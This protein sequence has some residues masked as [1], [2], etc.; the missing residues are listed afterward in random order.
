[1]KTYDCIVIGA[2]FYGLY[3]TKTLSEKGHKVLVLEFDDKPFERASFIN[4]ARVHN[5]YHY[6]RS[7]ETAQKSAHY[8]NRFTKD[9]DFAINKQFDQIYAISAKDS[10]TNAKQFEEFCKDINIPCE[11]IDENNY[12]KPGMVEAVFRGKEYAFDYKVIKDFLMEKI[13]ATKNVT[14]IYGSRI[15][16]ISNN[17][18]EI[19]IYD[20]KNNE[21]YKSD[22]VLN[23]TYA[24]LNQI[25]TLANLKTFQIK[26]ELCE[27]IF[28]K[29]SK[30]IDGVGLTIMDG[31]FF[32][33]MPFGLDGTY[34]L[35][36][37]HYTPHKT[38]FETLPNF[39]CME[40]NEFC[41]SN[42]LNNCNLCKF[43]PKSSFNEMLNLCN[44]YL[45]NPIGFETHQSAFAIKPIL[46]RAEGDDARPTLVEKLIEHPRFISVLSGKIDTVYDLDQ[47]LGEV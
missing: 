45:K 28:G 8:F 37:V 4:Q 42:V 3:A 15:S 32:S 33:I 25:L 1:M 34:S 24:S 38:S 21:I 41:N 20:S 40:K 36:A 44:L 13:E 31:P 35:S 10:L 22:F 7:K 29:A 11:K 47:V 19:E 12:F 39:D 17:G 18:K 30:F 9:F 16:K 46:K 6:P 26:Y 43:R 5:G 14:F 2:G 27:M 23:A